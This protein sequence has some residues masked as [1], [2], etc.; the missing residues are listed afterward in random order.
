M[1]LEADEF[2]RRFLLHIGP[3]GFVRIRHFGL[4]A[5]R[6][7]EGALAQCRAVLTV[8]PPAPDPAPRESVRT[9]MLRLTGIDIDRCP[10]CQLG[11]LRPLGP[12]PPA[13]VPWDT[14]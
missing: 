13:P 8:P 10:V 2:L 3:E 12:L 5:N 7:R 11:I 9:L 4:L 6:R 1:E 14:S